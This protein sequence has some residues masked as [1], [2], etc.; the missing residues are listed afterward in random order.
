MDGLAG[1]EGCEGCHFGTVE[2]EM[3]VSWDVGI[4]AVMDEEID[5]EWSCLADC[6]V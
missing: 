1:F 5:G 4:C 2:V 6:D 3:L